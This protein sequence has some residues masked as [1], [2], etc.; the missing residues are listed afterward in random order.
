MTQ[1]HRQRAHAPGHAAR[2]RLLAWAIA[3]VALTVVAAAWAWTPARD[4]I[5]LELLAARLDA[6]SGHPAAPLLVLAGFLVGGLLVLPVTLMVVLTVSAFGPVAGFC[7][8]LGGATLSALLGFA[9]GRLAGRRQ[10]ERL[11]GSRVHR[12]SRR[13]GDA[14]VITV[15]TLRMLPVTHFTVVSLTAGATHIRVRDFVL[16]T[17]LGMA[18]GIGAI[19]LFFDRLR[20]TAQDPTAGQFALFAAVSLGILAVLLALRRWARRRGAD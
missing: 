18:P 12:I 4:L 8:A 2:R 10:V 1:R 14:G 13:I 17:V 11:A 15:T 7:Y 20:A 5:R 19:T 3:L 6:F 9:L 16:G